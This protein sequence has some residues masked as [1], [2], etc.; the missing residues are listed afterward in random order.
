M[1]I[2]FRGYKIADV[3]DHDILYIGAN[4]NNLTKITTCARGDFWVAVPPHE[5]AAILNSKAA[6]EYE[7]ISHNAE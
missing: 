6:T 4:I 5:F 1:L 3:N 2:K 7:F